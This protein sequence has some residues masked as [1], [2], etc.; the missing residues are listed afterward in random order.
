MYHIFIHSSDRHLCCFHVLAI[1]N[2]AAMYIGVHGP[3]FK[4][5]FIYLLLHRVSVAAGR[6]FLV[7]EEGLLF[8]VAHKLLI[9][10]ASF[11]AEHG[12]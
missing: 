10:V 12:L 4:D 11:D 9:A 1:G 3:F 8:I 7:A 2:S 6:H 5:L